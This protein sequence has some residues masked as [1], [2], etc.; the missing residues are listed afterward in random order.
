MG[1]P[2]SLGYKL[3]KVR[4]KYKRTVTRSPEFEVWLTEAE[5][6]ILAPGEQD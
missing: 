2:A 6:S 1:D 3:M 5:G 4:Q